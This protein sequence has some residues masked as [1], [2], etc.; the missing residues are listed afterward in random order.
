MTQKQSKLNKHIGCQLFK[1]AKNYFLSGNP[2][3]TQTICCQNAWFL[4]I[5]QQICI[6]M[7]QKCMILGNKSSN[8]DI[9]VENH[10][11][12]LTLEKLSANQIFF[13]GIICPDWRT[14]CSSD[15]WLL[16]LLGKVYNFM[17]VEWMEWP[18]S[19]HK[20]TQ[21]IKWLKT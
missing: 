2:K 5:F 8:C 19:K 21:N 6:I 10:E 14:F 9:N 7:Q 13:L 16:C 12:K 3:F 17:Y 20:V 15:C 4:A 18:N 11:Y 1:G